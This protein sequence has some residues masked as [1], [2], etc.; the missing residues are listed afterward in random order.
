MNHIGTVITIVVIMVY[1]VSRRL[2]THCARRTRL[3]D[4]MTDLSPLATPRN[5]GQS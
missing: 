5:H 2:A 4:R 3:P 1:S